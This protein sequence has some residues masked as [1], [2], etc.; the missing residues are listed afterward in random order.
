MQPTSLDPAF[1][2]SGP[3]LLSQ[4]GIMQSDINLSDLRHAVARLPFNKAY[5]F[6]RSAV[7]S[8]IRRGMVDQAIDYLQQFDAIATRFN[9]DSPDA[10]SPQLHDIHAALLQILT[11]LYIESDRLAEAYTTAASALNL[12]VQTARRKDEAF[13]CTLASL[14]FDIATI[15]T[16]RDEA[17]QAERA[18][19]KS[20]KLFER[21]ARTNPS[22]YGGAH[23]MAL[24]ASTTIYRSR[25]RQTQTL[26]RCQAAVST[27]MRQS[28][29]GIA[30]ASQH[31][32]EALAEQGRTL[33]KMNRHREAVQYL[34][35]ALKYKTR[36]NPEFDTDQL[37]LSIDLGESLLSLKG[38][39]D[40]GVHL[41]NTMLYKANRLEASE[42]HRR[43]VH[44][45]LQAKDP[46]MGIFSFWH[47][48]FPR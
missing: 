18:I 28:G 35:R 6:F 27:Y 13:L 17:P 33:A 3:D 25:V 26:A 36:L 2:P 34:S 12:M 9:T 31:L 14:L 32:A 20:I 29:E 39:R 7:N 40:K 45:L 43:I 23:M 8:F 30:D 41:L 38:S 42:L 16:A 5:D 1:I 11:A 15:H 19:E 47:K 22:R 10:A 46:A 24:S 4:M 37:R 44:I 48:L 21:L